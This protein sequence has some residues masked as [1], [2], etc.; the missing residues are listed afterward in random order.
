MD[1]ISNMKAA[2]LTDEQVKYELLVRGK[3]VAELE[4][5]GSLA[6]QLQT[7]LEA[8]ITE[9]RD[10]L[11]WVLEM[12][13]A[14]KDQ[15]LVACINSVKEMKTRFD[16]YELDD[17]L[18]W[19]NF[20]L[21]R[22]V[23][24]DCRLK[25]IQYDGTSDESRSASRKLEVTLQW[26]NRMFSRYE[27][28]RPQTPQRNGNQAN[29][30]PPP[31]ANGLGGVEEPVNRSGGTDASPQGRPTFEYHGSPST[32]RSSEFFAKQPTP[33]HPAGAPGAATWARSQ[34]VRLVMIQLANAEEEIKREFKRV[35]PR[36]E[37]M[38]SLLHR[39]KLAHDQIEDI[40]RRI[41]A[42]EEETAQ[43]AEDALYKWEQIE[44]WT[45]SKMVND[46][47]RTK[48]N[49]SSTLRDTVSDR[50]Q[51]GEP[52]LSSIDDIGVDH[53]HD[54]HR[55]RRGITQKS[56]SFED[57]NDTNRHDNSYSDDRPDDREE[58]NLGRLWPPRNDT[59]MAFKTEESIPR[60]S[61]RTER[62]GY[63]GSTPW[64]QQ[65]QALS[66]AMGH[67]RFDGESK[68]QKLLSVNEFIGLLRMY[69]RSAR[70]P[71]NVLL[72][73]VPTQ[74]TGLAFQWWST[75]G[76]NVNIRTV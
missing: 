55:N 33:P 14:Q 19:D 64:Q 15:E 6:D 47:R 23:H 69:Q 1:R 67:R 52:F 43:L 10:P 12:T 29:G 27:E 45:V 37:V 72:G 38:N 32:F 56:V 44:R 74:M 39:L 65:M 41:T 17:T 51:D 50:R 36:P 5:N 63:G 22:L 49:A 11:D 62:S 70:I 28:E 58:Q 16:D 66:K 53:P 60:Y 2:D 68:D 7:I 46:G 20:V 30:P 4:A 59:D 42:A 75:V 40:T 61:S 48:T 18:A 76:S 71:D 73:A 26:V 31:A 9:Q 24:Y 21:S 13:S 25:R 34:D 57:D 8:E 35:E 3:N 54:P